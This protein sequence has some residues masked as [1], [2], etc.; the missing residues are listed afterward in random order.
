MVVSDTSKGSARRAVARKTTPGIAFEFLRL[1]ETG[2]F[3]TFVWHGVAP[4][5]SVEFPN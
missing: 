4:G 3:D 1:L 2:E 5:Y